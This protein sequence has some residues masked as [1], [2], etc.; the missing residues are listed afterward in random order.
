VRPGVDLGTRASYADLGQT[1]AEL[2]GVGPLGCGR[3]FLSALTAGGV[4]PGGG[5]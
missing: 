5:A 3:S 1:L 2:F 4:R